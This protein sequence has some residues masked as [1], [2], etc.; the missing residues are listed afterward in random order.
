M[1][2]NRNQPDLSETERP[3]HRRVVL[4]DAHNY[5]VPTGNPMRPYDILTA[6]RGEE[7]EF[8][9]EEVDRVE[10]LDR[11]HPHPRGKRLGT[12]EEYEDSV[13]K[14]TEVSPLE[15]EAYG[16]MSL[17][18][19]GAYLNQHPE[20]AEHLLLLE[21][22]KDEPR[23]QFLDLEQNMAAAHDE[24]LRAQAAAAERS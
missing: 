4:A 3:T 1:A 15:P 23:Q 14:E 7:V 11:T 24:Q 2:P 17:E 21:E 8:S 13:A 6:R 10:E 20:Q 22:G 18:E 19:V 9:Q 5:K 16:G 12:P